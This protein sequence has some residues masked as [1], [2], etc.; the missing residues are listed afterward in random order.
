ML[1]LNHLWDQVICPPSRS[2]IDLAKVA[3]KVSIAVAWRCRGYL[4]F[5]ITALSPLPSFLG[6]PFRFLI[7]VFQRYWDD[8]AH[9]PEMEAGSINQ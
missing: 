8:R 9:T 6:L 5:F 2:S 3:D 1:A 7:E 4:C